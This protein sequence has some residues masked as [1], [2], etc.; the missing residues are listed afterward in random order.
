MYINIWYL[1][2]LSKV[3]KKLDKVLTSPFYTLV[4]SEAFFLLNRCTLER[5]LTKRSLRKSLI[6]GSL[7][8][9]IVDSKS[10]LISIEVA[11]K[12]ARINMADFY[13]KC[14]EKARTLPELFYLLPDLKA[15]GSMLGTYMYISVYICTYA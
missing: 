14:R 10:K 1:Y 7:N 5:D 12:N 4:L 8:N 6:A 13:L 11:V 9:D 15:F 3:S 2:N